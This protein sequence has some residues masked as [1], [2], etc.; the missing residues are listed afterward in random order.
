MAG[1]PTL[2]AAQ[3]AHDLS[4]LRDQMAS[5]PGIATKLVQ[6]LYSAATLPGDVYSGK[7]EATPEAGMEFALNLAGASTPFPKPT[8]SLGIFGGKMAKTANHNMR[9]MAEAMEKAGSKA[10]TIWEATG[11]GRGKDGQ[12]RFEID[13]QNMAW[14]GAEKPT[15]VSWDRFRPLKTVDDA[16]S[17][18]ELFNAYPELKNIDFAPE[19]HALGSY[20]RGNKTLKLDPDMTPDGMRTVGLHELQHAVQEIEG[21]ARGGNSGQFK[22]PQVFER[23]TETARLIRQRLEAVGPDHP[24]FPILQGALAKLSSFMTNVSMKHGPHAQYRKLAGETESRNVELR[25][26]LSAKGRLES[27]PWHT[28]DVPRS[29]QKVIYR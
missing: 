3:R 26:D 4:L 8:N 24:D 10:D 9:E 22:N 14:K 15:P 16:F 19:W 23:A 18:P 2:N 7:R 1:V 5:D 20:S 27:P 12:W 13:D 29:K 25:K 11:W 17:H 21:F 6:G 28:E